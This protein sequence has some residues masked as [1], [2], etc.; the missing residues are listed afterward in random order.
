M[1]ITESWWSLRQFYLWKRFASDGSDWHG[2]RDAR[3]AATSGKRLRLLSELHGHSNENAT[4]PN[5]QKLQHSYGINIAITSNTN[6]SAS[7]ILLSMNTSSGMT[8]NT[9]AHVVNNLSIADK[10]IV[11]TTNILTE[12]IHLQDNSG[13]LTNYYT[14]TESD[15][16]LNAKQKKY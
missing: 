15:T 12:I 2:T 7:E 4:I 10:L 9:S 6:C 3:H 13:N 14:K 5:K 16:L 11:G 1:A 8:I